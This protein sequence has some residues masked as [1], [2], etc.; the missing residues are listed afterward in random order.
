MASPLRPGGRSRI[1]LFP[2]RI[3]SAITRNDVYRS[4]WIDWEIDGYFLDIQSGL[5]RHAYSDS[6][7]AT[8]LALNDFWSAKPLRAALLVSRAKSLT[9]KLKNEQAA[10]PERFIPVTALHKDDF[11][12]I[13][14]QFLDTEWDLD[15]DKRTVA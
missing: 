3:L 4:P 9:A 5:I 11:H 13:V 8:A 14:R 10:Q 1:T 6:S 15:L 7:V 12:K 2:E